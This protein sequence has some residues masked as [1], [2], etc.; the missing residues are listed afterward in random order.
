MKKLL[1]IFIS[2]ILMLTMCIGLTG[3]SDDDGCVWDNTGT[4]VDK[5][6][7]SKYSFIWT[8]QC[9]VPIYLGKDY[10]FTVEYESVN[11]ETKETHKHRIQKKVDNDTY[12][13]FK[14]GDTVSYDEVNNRFTLL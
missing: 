4:I 3:C 9:M 2:L 5:T 8:G 13:Q 7:H 6:E 12:N 11:P 14:I 1:A 10:Y